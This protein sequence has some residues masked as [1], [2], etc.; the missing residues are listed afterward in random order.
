MD[1][2][3]LSTEFWQNQY[4]ANST[5]WDR[6]EVHP[7]LLNWIK[8]DELSPC[9]IVVPGCGRGHEVTHMAQRGFDVTAIDYATAPIEF[10]KN[11][12]AT[13]GLEASL[14]AA[15]LFSFEV[16]TPYDAVYEQTCLC[17]IDPGLRPRYADL[18]YQWLR[19]GGQLYL[20]MV[21]TNSSHGP[22]FHCNPV[23]MRDLFSHRRWQWQE[24]DVTHYDHPS[25]Q[26]HELAVVLNRR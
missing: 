15:D 11:Q 9:R 8:L 25:G 6:G 22:P 18:V 23:E 2:S 4:E 1:N 7:A 5:G 17:A 13:Q 12:L 3:H 10:L 24:S 20:L 19:P 26:I 21:Q 14:I 16:S